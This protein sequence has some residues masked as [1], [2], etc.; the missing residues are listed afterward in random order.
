[1]NQKNNILNI[2]DYEILISESVGKGHP[3]KICDQI[4]DHILD[5]CLKID[6]ESRVACEVMAANTLIIVSGEITTKANIN[7]ENEV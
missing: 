3:D 1:M 6:S 4:S 2:K 7:V 5:A